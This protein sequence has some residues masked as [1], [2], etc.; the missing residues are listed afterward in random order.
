MSLR[1]EDHR[2]DQRLSRGR[3]LR[4]TSL[5]AFDRVPLQRREREVMDAVRRLF[6]SRTWTRKELARAMGWEINRITGRVLSLIE[7][8]ELEE[9]DERRDGAHLVRLALVQRELAL[10]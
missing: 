1:S 3:S 6:G 5:A 10:A 9:L 8:G 7:R 2:S 4:D